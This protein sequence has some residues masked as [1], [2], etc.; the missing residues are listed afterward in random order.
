M[1]RFLFQPLW[2]QVRTCTDRL[3]WLSDAFALVLWLKTGGLAGFV[4]GS[5]MIAICSNTS[6]YVCVTIFALV[7]LVGVLVGFEAARFLSATGVGLLFAVACSCQPITSR[8][9]LCFEKHVK[10]YAALLRERN[11]SVLC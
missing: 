11:T 5:N 3:G 6:V 1:I 4:L 10:I 2:R 7:L 9:R 8:T